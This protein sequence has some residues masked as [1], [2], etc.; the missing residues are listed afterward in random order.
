MTCASVI[1][2]NSKQI[3]VIYFR[4][5]AF[6]SNKLY[7]L[8][9]LLLKVPFAVHFPWLLH[10]YIERKRGFTPFVKHPSAS[11]CGCTVYLVSFLF[12]IRAISS[13]GCT[14]VKYCFTVFPVIFKIEF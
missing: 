10:M 1:Y 5:T 8:Y 11:L 4:L 6:L 3:H 9:P 7:T 2:L 12:D 14:A 13:L